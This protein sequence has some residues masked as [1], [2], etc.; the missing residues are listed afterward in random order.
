[1][2]HELAMRVYP[3]VS[4]LAACSQNCKWHSSL[5]LSAVLSLFCGSV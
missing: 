4:G 3:N 1:V 5:P 2:G